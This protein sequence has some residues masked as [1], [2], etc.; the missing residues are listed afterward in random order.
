MNLSENVEKLVKRFD[1]DTNP[2]MNKE[3][4]AELLEAQAEHLRGPKVARRRN[5]GQ[6]PLIAR[7]P[8]LTW[9]CGLATLSI[10]IISCLACFVLSGKVADLK[11]E[12]E[13]TRRG[14]VPTATDNSATINFYL[15]EHRDFVARHASMS[16]TTL[17]SSQMRVSPQDILY[18][19]FLDDEPES[20]SPGII[21]RGPS[22][23]LDI[24]SS[25]PPIISNGHTLTLAEARQIADF[26]LR[27][28]A[29]LHPGYRLDQIRR[30]EGRD[31]LQ[32]LYTDAINSV[33][34]FEQPLDGQRG[35]EAKDFREYAVYRQ[36]KQTG[37]TIL[38]CRDDELS[39]VLIGNADMSQ[40][41]N[42]AQSIIAA[43]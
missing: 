38:A 4:L 13:R 27:A 8:R 24:D 22:S 18:Y 36:N 9:I 14:L 42:M 12:L 43:K 2:V 5:A 1:I 39:Y 40:L 31:A 6:E 33:S 16:P 26:E 3:I 28:P 37:G 23:E 25:N 15:E 32:L 11:A 21:V 7:F 34:L 10:A 29:R 17:Q 35:L 20:M 19:E 41:M 30:I